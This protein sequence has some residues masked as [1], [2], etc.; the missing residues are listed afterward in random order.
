MSDKII[1]DRD[2]FVALSSDTRIEILKELDERRK[3]LSEMAKNL[4]CNKSAIYKHLFKLV[5]AELVKK[6]ENSAHKWVYYCLTWKGKNLLH[7]E[8]MK[9][10]LLLSSAIISIAGAVITTYLYVKEKTPSHGTCT[11]G[12]HESSGSVTIYIP[13]I[14]AII[15]AMLIL[16]S[17][18]I[19]KKIEKFEL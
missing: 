18:F 10:T 5:D 17:I 9:I 19:W 2:I 3:T 15:S 11:L 16:A 13:I 8:K 1:I 14:L 4:D 7:P 6:E 12:S